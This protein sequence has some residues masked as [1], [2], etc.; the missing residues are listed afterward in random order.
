MFLSVR[1]DCYDSFVGGEELLMA[2]NIHPPRPRPGRR[3]VRVRSSAGAGSD[4]SAQAVVSNSNWENLPEDV[5]LSV[6][7]QLDT[8]HIASTV[9]T[10]KQWLRQLASFLHQAILSQL[11]LSTPAIDAARR[12]SP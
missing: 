11:P 12:K 1:H 10:C 6:V 9:A 7:A 8:S 2:P 5:L 4:I 3:R